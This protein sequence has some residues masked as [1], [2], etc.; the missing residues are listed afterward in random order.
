MQYLKSRIEAQ[1]G[2]LPSRKVAPIQL[3]APPL[4]MFQD[5]LGGSKGREASTTAGFVSVLKIS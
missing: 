3:T 1:G 2:P 5:T 4:E